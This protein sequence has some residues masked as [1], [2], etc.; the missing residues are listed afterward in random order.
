MLFQLLKN[1]YDRIRDAIFPH[2]LAK[3]Q[4]DT[5][6]VSVTIRN[7]GSQK[8]V[9]KTFNDNAALFTKGNTYAQ[10]C[11]TLDATENTFE[12]G[13][14][15]KTIKRKPVK[16]IPLQILKCGLLWYTP[17]LILV[18]LPNAPADCLKKGFVQYDYENSIG[19]KLLLKESSGEDSPSKYNIVFFTDEEKLC[20]NPSTTIEVS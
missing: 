16:S 9:L 10:N 4:Y 13:I 8:I 3:D 20:E 17:A 2:R 6:G 5:F 15:E 1:F 12:L 19:Y 14:K 7:V 18:N 11:I